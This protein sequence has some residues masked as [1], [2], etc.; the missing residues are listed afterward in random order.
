MSK[1]TKNT[2]K[3]IKLLQHLM[4]G[5]YDYWWCLLSIVLWKQ[6]HIMSNKKNQPLGIRFC[7][8]VQLNLY[9]SAKYYCVNVIKWT[10]YQGR[11][12][13]RLYRLCFL[14]ICIKP[15]TLRWPWTENNNNKHFETFN[16]ALKQSFIRTI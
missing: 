13:L 12:L 2:T 4:R 5:V 8:N 1:E 11:Y 7:P 10:I 3:Y 14:N 6:S 15:N 9:V 16:F